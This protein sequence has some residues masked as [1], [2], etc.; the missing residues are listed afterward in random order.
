MARNSPVGAFW[1]KVLGF[2]IMRRIGSSMQILWGGETLL[3]E[4]A[5]SE[6]DT[7]S[8][9]APW[10]YMPIFRTPALAD[11]VQRLRD[12][13][14]HPL[15]ENS[16]DDGNEAI[17]ADP[18]GHPVAFRE[19]SPAA[20]APENIEARRR[21]RRGEAFNPGC[22]K[23]P[24]DIQELG[25]IRRRVQDVPRMADF[26]S[27]VVG[28]KRINQGRMDPLFDLGDNVLLELTDGG[29]SID[30]PQDRKGSNEYIIHRVHD[31]HG[32]LRK[33]EASGARIVNRSIP[34]YWGEIAYFAD[35]EGYLIGLESA[36][37]PEAYSPAKPA[38]AEGLEAERRWR[39]F[40]SLSEREK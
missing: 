30:P 28:Y 39:E 29:I 23:M 32:F 20:S 31:L 10:G 33:V 35:P 4:L 40:I 15:E 21:A 26:Y 14:L 38:L 18:E 2:P 37:H 6:A 3:I 5:F 11:L 9:A 34:V 16:L 27:T 13:G 7:P 8:S 17:F 36:F 12:L 1:E 24:G 22:G 25:W 19:R